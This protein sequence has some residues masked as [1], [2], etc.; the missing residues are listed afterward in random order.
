MEGEGVRG[1]ITSPLYFSLFVYLF[2]HPRPFSHCSRNFAPLSLGELYA[3]VT[4]IPVATINEAIP[5]NVMAIVWGMAVGD[6]GGADVWVSVGV[7]VPVTV[8]VTVCVKVVG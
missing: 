5:A 8:D 6:N 1:V 7:D 2:T 3:T 4:M